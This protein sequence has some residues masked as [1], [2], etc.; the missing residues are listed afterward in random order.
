MSPLGGDRGG[1]LFVRIGLPPFWVC[2]SV[3]CV[4]RQNFSEVFFAQSD[5]SLRAA[6]SSRRA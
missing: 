4:S 5:G 3:G 6:A 2:T 1:D